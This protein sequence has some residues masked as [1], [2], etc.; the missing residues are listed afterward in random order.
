MSIIISF[1][2]FSRFVATRN[3][4]C[5]QRAHQRSVTNRASADAP[6]LAG[7]KAICG[8]PASELN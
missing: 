4:L 7:R 2:L 1:H 6:A 5:Q 3:G 8:A